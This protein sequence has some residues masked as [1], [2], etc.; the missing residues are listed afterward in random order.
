MYEWRGSGSYLVQG[1]KIPVIDNKRFIRRVADYDDPLGTNTGDGFTYETLERNLNGAGYFDITWQV[2]TASSSSDPEAGLVMKRVDIASSDG[3][4][5]GTYFSPFGE[6][7]LVAPFPI[8]AGAKW[9]TA[10]VDLNSGRSLQISGQV[11][12]RQVIDMC[13]TLV[14]GWH[15]HAGWSDTGSK[16]TI[17][18]LVTP[19]FAGQIVAMTVDGTY[20][21]TDYE[22]AAYSIKSLKPK[23]FPE[24]FPH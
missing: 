8:K 11:L 7:L 4:K 6:G 22:K 21:A 13:G 20:F 19:Q 5:S 3:K 14:Q 24:G 15:I 18:Y 9:N 16:A 10:S 12:T 23:P 1:N 17:D 2:K